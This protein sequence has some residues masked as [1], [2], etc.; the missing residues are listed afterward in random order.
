MDELILVLRFALLV[1]SLAKWA[2]ESN[3]LNKKQNDAFG[4]ILPK[5]VSTHPISF[6][7]RDGS[8]QVRNTRAAK[9]KIDCIVHQSESLFR[10]VQ[11]KKKNT[12]WLRIKRQLAKSL[13]RMLLK[14]SEVVL[15][16]R[17]QRQQQGL[18]YL[19][20]E[21]QNAKPAKSL[22]PQLQKHCGMADLPKRLSQQLVVRQLKRLGS[23][24]LLTLEKRRSRQGLISIS[25]SYFTHPSSE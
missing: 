12:T 17:N 4:S 14:H 15:L 1:R 6:Y 25:K 3:W 9:S 20:Q 8:S 5:A 10:H 22:Q 2:R 7:R 18:R 13:L 11:T 24:N 19:K 21:H 23:Q 16:A